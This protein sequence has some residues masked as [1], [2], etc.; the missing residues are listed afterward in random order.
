MAVP[1]KVTDLSSAVAA[2]VRDGMT[3]ALE[4]FGHLIPFAA[5]PRDHPPGPSGPDLRAE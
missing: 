5:G 2:H 1:D 3:V 4:G